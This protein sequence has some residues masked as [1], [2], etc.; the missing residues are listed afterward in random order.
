M[1]TVFGYKAAYAR[2]PWGN[3]IKFLECS[4]KLLMGNMELRIART[5]GY[6]CNV[7]AK[8]GVQ[9]FIPYVF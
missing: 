2:D 3:V 6:L 9:L 1:L 5:G 4:F 8:R 7:I